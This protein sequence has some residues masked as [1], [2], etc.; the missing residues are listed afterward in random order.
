[1]TSTS[2]S[3]LA[4]L[5]FKHKQKTSK[6]L[7]LSSTP[8]VILSPTAASTS[9]SLSS[10]TT[11][12]PST[13]RRPGRMDYRRE[14]EDENRRGRSGEVKLL[15]FAF[16]TAE[17]P[18]RLRSSSLV[19]Y[20]QPI[21]PQSTPAS[22]RTSQEQFRIEIVPVSGS[23]SPAP[24]PVCASPLYP[25]SPLLPESLPE[26]DDHHHQPATHSYRYS[27]TSSRDSCTSASSTSLLERDDLFDSG[28]D[29]MDYLMEVD[30]DSRMDIEESN[31]NFDP[32][33]AYTKKSALPELKDTHAGLLRS[34]QSRPTEKNQLRRVSWWTHS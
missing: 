22:S 15:R 29:Q 19:H 8:T 31:L 3:I 23:P 13:W 18:T 30:E 25:I 2:T 32:S 26:I 21:V 14:S 28:D 5:L 9:S 12:P 11:S 24:T 33:T 34:P 27:S 6:S 20:D 4:Q 1:M 16:P 17:Q 10:V 7:D